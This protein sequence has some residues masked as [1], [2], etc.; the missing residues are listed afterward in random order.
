MLCGLSLAWAII[1]LASEHAHSVQN[2]QVA[3][4]V[5]AIYLA[6]AL[7]TSQIK[8]AIKDA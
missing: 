8:K 7:A 5:S 6:A 2:Q 4:L 1:A 3:T